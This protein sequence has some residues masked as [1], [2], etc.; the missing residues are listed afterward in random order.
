[1]SVNVLQRSRSQHSEVVCKSP[2]PV[3]GR[4]GSGFQDDTRLFPQFDEIILSCEISSAKLDRSSLPRIQELIQEVYMT[5]D[6][7]RF[8]IL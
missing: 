4:S 6:T 8:L 1:M 7:C 5:G 2:L 3:E